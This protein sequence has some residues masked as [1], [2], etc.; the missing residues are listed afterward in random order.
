MLPIDPGVLLLKQDGDPQ[1]R[2][3]WAKVKLIT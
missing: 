2:P 1:E 3:A